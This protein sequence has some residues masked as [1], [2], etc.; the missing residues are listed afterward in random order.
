MERPAASLE[1]GAE[2]LDLYPA[3]RSHEGAV[4]A[5]RARAASV[6]L[7]AAVVALLFFTPLGRGSAPD[8]ARIVVQLHQPI[9]LVAPPRE[10]TQTPPNRGKVGK[11]FDLKSLLPRRVFVP[12]SMPPGAPP[13]TLPEP[14]K[15][16]PAPAGAPALPPPV[17]QAEE[18]PKLAFERPSAPRAP[19]PAKSLGSAKLLQPGPSITEMRSGAGRGRGA[20]GL[21]LEDIPPALGGAGMDISSP[22]SGVGSSLELLSDPKGVD[23]KPYLIQIL[24]SVKRNWQSVLPESARLG[25]RGRVVIQFAISRDGSVPKLVIA[26]PSGTDALDRAAVAGIS[27]TNP[28]PPLPAEFSGDNIRLQFVFLY[29]VRP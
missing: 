28:F 29:N 10:L 22:P 13:A 5:W 27:A 23:F 26:S 4:R 21:V 6:G 20:G 3:W 15:M 7:H 1:A 12:P 11:E 25:R 2:E 17:I 16:L 8:M 19:D 14:P 9:R 24:A 18:Q